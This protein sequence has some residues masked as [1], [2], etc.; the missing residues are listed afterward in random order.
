MDR[1]AWW[2]TVHRVT[3]NQARLS[4]WHTLSLVSVTPFS[5]SP[6]QY[7]CPLSNL[8]RIFLMAQMVKN[9]PAMQ[10]TQVWS[11]C[12]EDCLEK[13]MASHSSILVWRIPWTE[14]PDGLQSKGSQSAGHDWM[15]NT[16][17]FISVAAQRNPARVWELLRCWGNGRC[18][19]KGFI[20]FPASARR[21]F[22]K[23]LTLL[24]GVEQG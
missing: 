19:Q 20:A 8:C 6:H 18:I 14:E 4:D 9:L 15:T 3:K 2:A 1:G 7:L 5:P 23:V 11:P 21:A 22:Q 17:T 16:F 12:W 10:E 13:E 24:L